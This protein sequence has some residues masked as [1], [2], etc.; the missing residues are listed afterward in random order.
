MKRRNLVGLV[1]VAALALAGLLGPGSASATV[2]CKANE[3]PCSG[4]NRLGA[5]TELQAQLATGSKVLLTI[6]TSTTG[7]GL[8]C[9]GSS[10][11]ATTATEG[12][13][14]TTVEGKL[15]GPTFS[16][17]ACSSTVLESGSFVLHHVAGTMNAAM[18]IE[19]FEWEVRCGIMHCI[20]NGN[21]TSGLT[22]EGGAPGKI[23]ANK[24]TLP[25]SG[26]STLL[27]G[28]GSLTAEYEVTKPSPL[29]VAPS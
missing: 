8:E 25:T 5:P 26:E 17:C 15:S 20:F 16:E 21:I 22:L 1:V 4:A 13:S 2:L 19:G 3:T 23:L 7:F 11:S 12:S 27:C 6:S 18:E 10:L 24:A 9:K 14:T 28:K 29:Y